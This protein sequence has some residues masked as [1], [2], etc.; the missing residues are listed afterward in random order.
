MIKKFKRIII[1]VL[2]FSIILTDYLYNEYESVIPTIK[3]SN[4]F[5]LLAIPD[6][7]KC[8]NNISYSQLKVESSNYFNQTK[9]EVLI[10]SR[11]NSTNLY[12]SLVK[13]FISARI[14]FKASAEL[15]INPIKTA[16]IVFQDYNDYLRYSKS[17]YFKSNL[18]HY[19]IGVVVF[20]TESSK[21][22]QVDVFECKLNNENHMQEFLHVTKF[23]TQAVRIDKKFQYNTKFRNLF[24]NNNSKSILKCE[25]SNNNTIEDGLFVSVI[26]NVKHAFVTLIRFNDIWLLK[27]LFID[28][29]RYLTNGV[30]DVGLKRFIQI[31][32][33]D[34]FCGLS[35]TRMIPSDLF[36]LLKLQDELS[37]NYFS[38]E[39]KFKF[40]LG[41]LAMLLRMKLINYS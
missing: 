23:N 25:T 8:M 10:I 36:E 41:F 26:N 37:K 4:E 28:A 17:S 18:T 21:A 29:L 1:V 35:G 14:K 38:N 20:N 24:F 12:T 11:S 22:D 13:I 5:R 9:N 34:I 19:K 27:L 40:N 7:Y 3:T 16:L 15:V 32:I 2:F 30:I 33:D 31:D 39:T 6:N